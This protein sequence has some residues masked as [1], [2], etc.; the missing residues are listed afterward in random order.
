MNE[1]KEALFDVYVQDPQVAAQNPELA[2]HSLKLF[3]E[4]EIGD[5]PT[6]ARFAVV[7][8]NGDTQELAAPATW[9]NQATCFRKGR[10]KVNRNFT[11]KEK[12]QFHQ[13]QVWAWVHHALKFYEEDASLGRSIPW[14]FEG[15]RL[16]LVP[17]AGLGQNAYYDRTSKSLQFY[18]YKDQEQEEKLVYTCLS[19]D[20][21]LHEFGHAILDGIRPGFLQSFSLETAAL[22][23]FMGDLTAILMLLRNNDFRKIVAKEAEVDEISALA[24]LS[25]IAE[26]FGKTVMGKPYLRS[27]NNQDTMNS[28]H[29]QDTTDPH[30]LST[31]LTGTCFEILI[32]LSKMYLKRPQNANGTGELESARS[33]FWN[34]IQRA[35]RMF[36]QPL[37]L[38]PPVDARFKDY[39]LAV[40]RNQ[41][42]SDPLDPY[43]YREVMLEIFV[44]RG[45]LSKEDQTLLLE[46]HYQFDLNQLNFQDFQPHYLWSVSKIDAY[47]FVNNN[48]KTFGIPFAKDFQITDLYTAQKVRRQHSKMPRQ[49][50][51]EYVW[52]EEITL[53]GAEYGE[54]EGLVLALPCGGTLVVDE[55]DN[56]IT[57]AF[58]PGTEFEDEKRPEL[59]LHGQQRK[60][61]FLRNVQG[62]H[63]AGLIGQEPISS[64]AGIFAPS[65]NTL[66]LKELNGINQLVLAPSIDLSE[67]KHQ[68]EQK[69][70]EI[71]F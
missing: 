21:V 16:I 57:W 66:Q 48:R 37:D 44:R 36:L 10:R 53:N 27:A 18:F 55:D 7:D 25:N 45:I 61:A 4:P 40:L 38:L 23:E 17:H 50:V 13:V 58:K 6:S 34:T 1:Q 49:F 59:L 65:L 12:F 42:I 71:S 70:W 56:L 60:A 62:F 15:N 2:F 33:A 46:P 14:A 24:I 5:G 31:V 52:Q 35:Q 64:A 29:I 43:G 3:L 67:T 39:A 11:E 63:T 8:Y 19:A 54:L 51:L 28:A 20:I 68:N 69:S 22:H 9:D 30:I 47:H 41:E 26:E 32:E